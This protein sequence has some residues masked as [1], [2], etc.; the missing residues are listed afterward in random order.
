[1]LLG[2]LFAHTAGTVHE[3]ELVGVDIEVGERLTRGRGRGRSLQQLPL[4]TDGDVLPRRHGERTREESGK[5]GKED[6]AAGDPRGANTGDESEVRE[7]PV[8][9][10]EDCRPKVSRDSATAP[11]G[12]CTDNFAVNTLALSHLPPSIP[13]TPIQQP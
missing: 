5:A 3:C 13:T 4:R 2:R 11:L 12:E 8:V 1:M 7:Q 10:T 6:D 9:G